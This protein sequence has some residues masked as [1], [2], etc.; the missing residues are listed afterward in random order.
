MDGKIYTVESPPSEDG[1]CTI[2]EY[3]QGQSREVLP[4][5][6]SARTAVHGYGGGAL[7]TTS[8]GAVIFAD[9]K[10][11]GV[12]S[13]NPATQNVTAVVD[14]EPQVFFADFDVH[15]HHP[16]W[17][18]AVCEDHRSQPESD[19]LVALNA[20][21]R[22]VHVLASGADFY[23]YPRFSPAGDCICWIQWDHPDMPWTGTK[24]FLGSWV[25]DGTLSGVTEIDGEAHNVSINQ[26]HWGLDGTLFYTSDRNGYWQLAAVRKGSVNP[27]S[28]DLSGLEKGEFSSP[29]WRL[30]R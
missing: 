22:T 17:I 15:P 9:W 21:D 25:G 18:L 19:A 24:L 28:I 13:L 4:A 3:W 5:G 10:T 2:V 23:T 29:E 1:R 11:R 26:P 27:Q 7:A 8:E 30:G 6:Y 12:F 20:A 14:A 16:Q